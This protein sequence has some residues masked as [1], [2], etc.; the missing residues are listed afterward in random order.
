MKFPTH[1]ET[2]A[3]ARF[4]VCDSSLTIRN[5]GR[6]EGEARYVPHFWAVVLDG[7]ADETAKGASIQVTPE[8]KLR[9][10]ELK[11][12]QRI[13]LHQQENGFIVQV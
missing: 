10:P 12:R 8:D 5:P 4:T 1:E 7:Q 13:V 3:E 2:I 11:R 6:F 9:F